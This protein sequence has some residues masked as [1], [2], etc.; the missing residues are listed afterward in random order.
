MEFLRTPAG[1][2]VLVRAILWGYFLLVIF[3]GALRKWFL[4][5]LSTPLLLVR[6]PLC[7]A[8]LCLGW[9]LLLRTIWMKW[10]LI[11]WAIALAAIVFAVAVG[12]GDV[13]TAFYGARVLLL[14]FPIIFLYGVVFNLSDAWRFARVLLILS[15]PMTILIAMQYSL[16]SSHILNIAPGG[17]GT[18][19]FTGALGKSRPPGTFSFVNGL[20]SFYSLA[21]AACAAWFTGSHRRFPGWIWFSIAALILALPVSISRTIFFNYALV[22]AFTVMAAILAGKAVRNFLIGSIAVG[23]L[24][25]LVS[26]LHLFQD[27]REAFN[28]RW[29]AATLAEGGEDG[30]AGVLAQ[31]VG[32]T[33][34]D[35]F[36]MIP[37]V[38]LAGAG[39]GLGTN[40]G[41]VRISGE[42]T[43][44]I[45]EGAWG[46]AIG[47]MGPILG[48][49]VILFRVAFGCLLVALSIWQA[50]K[51]NTLPLILGGA[52]LPTIF[53]GGTSQPTALGF[54][55]F[56]A[57]LALAACNS[58]FQG[59]SERF[60][61]RPYQW[62][63]L[64]ERV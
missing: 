57:G 37:E 64:P 54:L 2:V 61:Y 9:P 33:F 51:G 62:S 34:L 5:A 17:E 47:E 27:A 44:L 49:L 36:E 48:G 38:P 42:K 1:R 63:A 31:R 35:G 39:I 12:H 14:H 4:P 50:K 32:G 11:L 53:L 58:E 21:A 13:F 8:A 23:V 3:E 15:I 60:G 16:P 52:V 40:V 6:D 43:F 45:A 55:V 28:A 26:Q 18:A 10:I 24:F 30:V 7:I 59:T 25:L 29:Q 22:A 46:A 56:G 20:S 19:G 41:A